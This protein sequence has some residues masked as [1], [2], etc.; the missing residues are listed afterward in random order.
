[1]GENRRC[2]RV[3]FTFGSLLSD[4]MKFSYFHFGCSPAI[5]S[6]VSSFA[7]NSLCTVEVLILSHGADHVSKHGTVW[8][9]W[10]ALL[11]SYW[12]V[13]DKWFLKLLDLAILRIKESCRDLC[14]ELFKKNDSYLLL[15]ICCVPSGLCHCTLMWGSSLLSCNWNHKARE[16]THTCTCTGT[17]THTKQWLVLITTE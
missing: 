5:F 16:N 3:F 1:M 13:S 4:L 7:F 11:Y 14:L 17:N 6:R 8:T 10:V 9:V 15:S 2:S 12:H